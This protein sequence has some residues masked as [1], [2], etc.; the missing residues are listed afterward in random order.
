M[1]HIT[2]E[3]KTGGSTA[4]FHVIL[5]V[6]ALFTMG[7]SVNDTITFKIHSETIIYPARDRWF[8]HWGKFR[9]GGAE[10]LFHGG[11]SGTTCGALN[12]SGFIENTQLVCLGG[13]CKY[14]YTSTDEQGYE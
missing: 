13:C 12:A 2:H 7:D 14:H 4:C 11:H 1:L 9:G 6:Q 3:R 10:L 8:S 5:A